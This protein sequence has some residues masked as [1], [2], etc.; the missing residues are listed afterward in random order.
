[1]D[2]ADDKMAERRRTRL[3]QLVAERFNGNQ[4]ALAPAIGRSK[5]QVNQ[6]LTG[7]RSM[8]EGSAR[9]IE[10]K[11]RLSPGWMDQYPATTDKPQRDKPALS[12]IP[13]AGTNPVLTDSPAY[14]V[15]QGIPVAARVPLISWARAGSWTEVDD[16]LHPGD[17]LE[18]VPVTGA[19][20]RAAFALRVVGDSMTNPDDRRSLVD[21]A[22]VI[23]DPEREA[24][25]GSI[26]L[27]KREGE[28]S[29]TLKLLWFDGQ[30]P[31]LKPLNDR[32]PI[33][34]MPADARIIGVAVQVTQS[35]L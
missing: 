12:E 6:W 24:L 34:P 14:Q 35:L 9:D 20:S 15:Q 4:S 17:A 11:L 21:G 5:A 29:A 13:R 22:V 33:Q 23:I 32:Y 31:Y 30:Q 3:A 19:V 10:R 2:S 16:P 7:H 26:V 18:W 1:M 8:T 27:A 25:H 28:Q